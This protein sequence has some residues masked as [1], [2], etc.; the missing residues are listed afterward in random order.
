MSKFEERQQ[1]FETKFVRDEELHFKATA[2]AIKKI[3]NGAGAKMG[4]GDVYAGVIVG[5]LLEEGPQ[6]ALKKIADDL[7]AKGFKSEADDL[8]YQFEKAH[9]AEA[10]RLKAGQ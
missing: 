9:A 1:A 7:A 4:A 5:I 8:G 6:A 2:S 10:V 3:A